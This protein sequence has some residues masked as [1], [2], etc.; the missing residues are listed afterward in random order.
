[1]IF[2]KDN[3]RLNFYDLSADELAFMFSQWRS[4]NPISATDLTL[5]RQFNLFVADH[6]RCTYDFSEDEFSRVVEIISRKGKHYP[7]AKKTESRF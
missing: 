4:E 2:Y 6:L 5:L 3:H 1:M 7:V